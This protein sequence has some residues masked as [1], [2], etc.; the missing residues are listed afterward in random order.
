MGRKLNDVIDAWISGDWGK[1]EPT[2]EYVKEV[3][4]IRSADIIPIYHNS[5]GSAATR[6]I[7]EKSFNKN[8]LSVGDIIVEKSGGTNTCST[9]R[10]IYVTDE[11]I[12]K[13]TP[14]V[15]SNFCTAFKVKKEW[16]ALYVYY[17]L[18]FLHSQ[19]V[20]MN[21]EGK[22]SGIH[23]LDINAA[24][25]AIEIPDIDLP[26]QKRI[27]SILNAIDRKITHNCAINQ[28]LATPVHS[29]TMVTIRHAA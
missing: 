29:S 15:C 18:R 23:N 9:G 14:L 19:G 24:Y 11:I 7:T 12:R 6:Y 21:Y 3:Y 28:N 22:T 17:L 5:F 13:N 1:E 10:V 25:N 20:F 26:T 16:D 8:L 2:D 27:S 4:C